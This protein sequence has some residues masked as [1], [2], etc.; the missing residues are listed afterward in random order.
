MD[1][2]ILVPT[3]SLLLLSLTVT[4]SLTPAPV[5]VNDELKKSRR[6]GVTANEAASLVCATSRGLRPLHP[7]ARFDVE[8]GLT[9]IERGCATEA[10]GGR[11]GST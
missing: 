7:A 4:S 11:L 8:K 6:R 3:L 2:L 5:V 1:F 10:D 9:E